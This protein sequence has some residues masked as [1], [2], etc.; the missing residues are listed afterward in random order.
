MSGL[1]SRSA[2]RLVCG[3]SL[4]AM[5]CIVGCADDESESAKPGGDGSGTDGAGAGGGSGGD[6]PKT[7]QDVPAVA[8]VADPAV[9]CP[10]NFAVN[11]PAPGANHG[12]Q[13][14]GQARAVHVLLPDFNVHQGP[15]PLF[16]AFNGTS[17]DGPEF[18]ERA[19]LQDFADRGFVVVAPSSEGNGAIWPVW[20]AMH[21]PDKPYPENRDLAL[22]DSLIQCMGAHYPVDKNRLYLG[23]HSAGGI[24]S[25]FMLQQRSDVFAG[26]IV[27][28]GIYDLTQPEQPSA[29]GDLFVIVT[30]GGDND[31]YSGSTNTGVAVPEINFVEQASIASHFYV[32]EPAVGHVNCHGDDF[33]HAWLS[34]INTTMIDLLLAHPKGLS[35]ADGVTVESS[36]GAG[37]TCSAEPYVFEGGLSVT[38]PSSQ[39]EPDCQTAC[40]LFADCAVENSTVGPALEPE[41]TALGFSGPNNTECGGC[42]TNCE[43]QA[44]AP[45]DDEVLTCISDIASSAMCGPGV[46]GALPAIDAVNVCCEGRSDSGLCIELC[47]VLSTGLAESFLPNCAPLLN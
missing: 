4:V 26:G 23:G 14:S 11:G 47:T 27:G 29:L 25:N 21:P 12:Y 3:A 8:I 30:W 15:R 38:C 36:P 34:N 22:V 1:V 16:V 40:Q 9:A 33:G 39:S 13:V 19:V 18:A 28:S 17:E 35:G 20:D 5:V 45:A 37:V 32:S 10:A 7:P 6:V 43:Q 44:K 41:L 2:L 24:M 42:V 31:A 46:D